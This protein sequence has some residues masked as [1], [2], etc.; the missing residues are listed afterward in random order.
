MVTVTLKANI[1]GKS[2]LR[3]IVAESHSQVVKY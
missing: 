3:K 2:N 1:I